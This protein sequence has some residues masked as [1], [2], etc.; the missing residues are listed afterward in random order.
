MF[1][2]SRPTYTDT[3]TYLYTFCIRMDQEEWYLY[4]IYEQNI[5]VRLILF[6][7]TFMSC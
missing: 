5:L 6:N 4:D 1:M 7:E 3:S 2:E